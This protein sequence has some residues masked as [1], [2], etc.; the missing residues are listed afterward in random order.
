MAKILI[1]DDDA[2]VRTFISLKLKRQNY[3]VFSASNGVEGLEKIKELNPD[4]I[5]LD[6]IMPGLSGYDVLKKVNEN[7]EFMGIPIIMLTARGQLEDKIKGLEGGAYDYLTKPFEPKELEVR[8]RSLLKLRNLQKKLIK[9]ERLAA[10]GKIALSIKSDVDEPLK[11]IITL[12][13]AIVSEEV[14]SEVRKK[15]ELILESSLRIQNILEKLETLEDTPVRDYLNGIKM[16][17]I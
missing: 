14:S 11:K 7:E 5:I 10:V 3:E 12:A 16:I 15:I 2:G 17:D 6:V 4:L 8:A 1:I 9:S 13:S